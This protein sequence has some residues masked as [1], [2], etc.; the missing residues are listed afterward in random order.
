M[1]VLVFGASGMVGGGVLRE[2]LRD[3]GVGRVIAVGRRP[4][5]VGAVKL[6]EFVLPDVTK[7][8]GVVERLGQVDACFFCLGTTSVG[9]DEREYRRITF[10]LTLSVARQLVEVNPAM[11]FVYVSGAG[12]DST[13][14]GAR[15]WARV[16][17][18]TEN[19]LLRLPFRAVFMFRPGV[20]QPLHGARSNTALYRVAYRMLWPFLAILVVASPNRV[21][22]T[23]RVGRAMIAVARS[24]SPRP[25]VETHEIN[26]LGR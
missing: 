2:A 17:G 10:D 12:T 15:M 5:G 22:T 14:Q 21:T 16:K 8:N 19:A 4:L 11:T 7:L 25:V 18:A 9:K 1:D 20:I 13:E 23:E 3:P 6:E 24:G 26:R